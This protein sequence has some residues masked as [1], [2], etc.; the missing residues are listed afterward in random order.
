MEADGPVAAEAGPVVEEAVAS[1]DLEVE[2]EE[3]AEQVA[4]GREKV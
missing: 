2:A 3:A 1:E 4:A